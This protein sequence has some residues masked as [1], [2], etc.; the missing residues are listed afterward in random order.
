MK[1]EK[2]EIKLAEVLKR[3]MEKG[4]WTIEAL[5]LESGVPASTLREWRNGRVPK[6]PVQ[7]LQ[8]SNSLQLSLEK[9]Y[10]D[11]NSHDYKR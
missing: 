6:N 1:K 4:G 3:E 10:F 7:V 8:L 2:Y 9:L 5:S 11:S